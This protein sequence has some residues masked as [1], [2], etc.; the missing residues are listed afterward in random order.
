MRRKHIGDTGTTTEPAINCP[1]CRTPSARG[2]PSLRTQW[3][4]F[5]EFPNILVFRLEPVGLLGN[6]ATNVQLPSQLLAEDLCAYATNAETGT[7]S[8]TL[9]MVVYFVGQVFADTDGAGHYYAACLSQDGE[10]WSLYNDE[11]VIERMLR[12]SA[13]MRVAAKQASLPPSYSFVPTTKSATCSFCMLG[14][15][16]TPRSATSWETRVS[17]KLQ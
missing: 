2:S 4:S 17:E 7:K 13:R 6:R 12:T 1:H 16:A 11:T 8:Y 15:T 14:V 3:F 5:S 9:S 10:T